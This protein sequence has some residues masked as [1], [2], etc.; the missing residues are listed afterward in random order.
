MAGKPNSARFPAKT[1]TCKVTK[2]SSGVAYP[3]N[4]D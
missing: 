2:L 4:S 3:E 1:K